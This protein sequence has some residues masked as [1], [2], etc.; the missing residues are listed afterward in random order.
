MNTIPPY[1]RLHE[2]DVKF[3]PQRDWWRDICIELLEAHDDFKERVTEDNAGHML[4]ARIDALR[5]AI[6]ESGK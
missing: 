1:P 2:W 5:K 4:M 3:N 6:S